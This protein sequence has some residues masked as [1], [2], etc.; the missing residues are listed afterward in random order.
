MIANVV[1]SLPRR[2]RLK[3]AAILRHESQ[4]YPAY[5][6]MIPRSEWPMPCRLEIDAPRQVWRSNRFLA[7][8]YEDAGHSRI[9][10]CRTAI[11]VSGEY[12]DAIAWEDLQRLKDQ[13][14][15]SQCWAVECF[16]PAGDVVNVANMRHLWILPEPPEFGWR[17]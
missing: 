10:V 16:P 12:E 1:R 13:V 14:G 3:A 8:V 7:C 11:K 4:Q 15:F 2:E 9:S 17:K 5:P 6:V